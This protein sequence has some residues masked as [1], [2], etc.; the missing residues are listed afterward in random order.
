MHVTEHSNS[1][2]VLDNEMTQIVLKFNLHN[3]NF[4]INLNR[5]FTQ[6]TYASLWWQLVLNT[7]NL[8]MQ[9][10]LKAA[11]ATHV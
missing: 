6:Y 1:S 5:L 3:K 7:A 2:Y 11:V 4:L 8:W 10:T 9:L